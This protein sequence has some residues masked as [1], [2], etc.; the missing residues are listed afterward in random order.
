MS[1][2][3]HPTKVIV[4]DWQQKCA[5]RSSWDFIKAMR[6]WKSLRRVLFLTYIWIIFSE[7][8][9]GEILFSVLGIFDRNMRD[10]FVMEIEA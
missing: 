7:V 8:P 10:E 1:W 4:V 9:T 3:V 2:I 6:I 5:Y